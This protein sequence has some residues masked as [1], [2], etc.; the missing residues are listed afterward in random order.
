MAY[1]GMGPADVSDGYRVQLD[2]SLRRG[3]R[4]RLQI[5]QH[6]ACPRLGNV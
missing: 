1:A 5:D 2:M 3:F 6:L 4:H